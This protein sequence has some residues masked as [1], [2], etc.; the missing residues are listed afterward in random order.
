MSS[1][2]LLSSCLMRF[3]AF[4]SSASSPSSTTTTTTEVSKLGGGLLL[5][6][7][8]NGP[9]TEKGKNHFHF[10]LAV[11]RGRIFLLSASRC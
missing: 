3:V 10:Q 1:R 7:D 9:T 2:T 11:Q 8:V 4:F 6:H 5:A